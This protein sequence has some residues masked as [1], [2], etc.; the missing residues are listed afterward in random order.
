MRE[1][2][3]VIKVEKD[4]ILVAK[5]ASSSC[6]SCAA[7]KICN[8][9]TAKIPVLNPKKYDIRIGDMVEYETPKRVSVTVLSSLLYGI[10]IV[11]LLGLS[12]SLEKLFGFND[13]LSL[14]IGAVAVGIYYFALN[15]Y[16]KKRANKFL[17]YIVK[18]LGDSTADIS[19]IMMQ[20]H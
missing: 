15:V 4:T 6:D 19:S 17:P 10:P 2:A 1:T 7:K 3:K 12:V 16:S 8:V 20:N 11:I 13:Y 14:G 18:K 5:S 9:S